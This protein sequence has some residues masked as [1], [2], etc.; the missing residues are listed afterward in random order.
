MFTQL[1]AYS[2]RL[3]QP[4]SNLSKFLIEYSPYSEDLTCR[5]QFSFVIWQTTAWSLSAWCEITRQ[6]LFHFCQSELELLRQKHDDFIYWRDLFF[7]LS[8]YF[9][10]ALPHCGTGGCAKVM[11]NA[12][13]NKLVNHE[14]GNMFLAGLAM[15]ANPTKETIEHVLELC[16]ENPGRT[17][18]L[19]LG[20]LIHKVCESKPQDCNDQ[21]KVVVLY[22]SDKSFNS[23][24]PRYNSQ[25]SPPATTLFKPIAR[26]WC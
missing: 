2:Q 16:E 14:R 22:Q 13:R 1:Q 9:Y 12:I 8:E 5:P 4:L 7:S 17:A 19:T 20:T 23:L 26:I 6:W 3:W 10:D 21:V 25:L 24:I 18:M 15:A 11:S